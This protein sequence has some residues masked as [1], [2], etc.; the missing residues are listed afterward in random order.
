MEAIIDLMVVA[1]NKIF[2]S[3]LNKDINLLVIFRK[4]LKIILWKT[5]DIYFD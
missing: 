4:P 5:Q 1:T 3:M 2:C